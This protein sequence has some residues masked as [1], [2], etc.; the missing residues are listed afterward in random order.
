MSSRFCSLTLV[1]SRQ[2]LHNRAQER[3]SLLSYTTNV[4]HL[5]LIS[6]Q[7]FFVPSV[8][9][10]YQVY[11]NSPDPVR[12]LLFTVVAQQQHGHGFLSFLASHTLPSMC[13]GYLS[14]L[15]SH[16]LSALALMVPCAW[17][18]PSS[19]LTKTPWSLVA[20]SIFPCSPS[21]C[22]CLRSLSY[23]IHGMEQC[24]KLEAMIC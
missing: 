18:S 1:A 6:H 14:L 13:M 3:G 17:M 21:P 20:F 4:S 2:V 23:I 10:I 11:I 15:A 5:D 7:P 8:K 12:R 16:T 9:L 19:S 22:F 24:Q